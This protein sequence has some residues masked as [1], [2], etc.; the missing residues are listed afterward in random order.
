M[1]RRREGRPGEMQGE[2][3]RREVEKQVQKE[4]P[5]QPGGCQGDVGAERRGLPWPRKVSQAGL[6]L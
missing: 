4:R 5:P 1:K 2:P 6:F 3:E